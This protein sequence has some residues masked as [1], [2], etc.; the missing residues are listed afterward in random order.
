MVACRAHV[1]ECPPP[2]CLPLR[3][4]PCHPSRA[5]PPGPTPPVPGPAAA[6]AG[7][8]QAGMALCRLTPPGGVRGPA[9]VT[10]LAGSAEPGITQGCTRCVALLTG[11]GPL[12]DVASPAGSRAPAKSALGEA[13][14]V[15]APRVIRTT[16]AQKP[17]AFPGMVRDVLAHLHISWRSRWRSRADRGDASNALV[18]RVQL[19]KLARERRPQFGPQE[20][21]SLTTRALGEIASW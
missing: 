11:A 15:A 12:G 3:Q 7:V 5:R 20:V 19:T 10:R 13:S 6:A 1:G 21:G 9:H 8:S 16:C 17:A 14:T 18:P 2:G 4:G